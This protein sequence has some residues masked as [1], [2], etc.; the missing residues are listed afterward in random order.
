MPKNVQ[1]RTN[2]S[3]YLLVQNLTNI[4]A[5]ITS[6]EP[7]DYLIGSAFHDFELTIPVIGEL[8]SSLTG[9]EDYGQVYF[10]GPTQMV[11][12]CPRESMHA[13]A[14]CCVHL[15]QT[16]ETVVHA[17]VSEHS[18]CTGDNTQRQ[19]LKDLFYEFQGIFSRDSY[20]CGITDIYTA[21][22]PTDPNAPAT[23]IHQ[24]K[25]LLAAFESIQGILDS[26]LEKKIIQECN[27]TYNSPLWPVL[28]PSGKW[29]LTIDYRQLNKQVPLS[30]WPMILLD[31]ELAVT[32]GKYF[33]TVDGCW[34]MKVD[35]VDQHKLAFSF[36][37]RQFT[38]N[39]CPFGYSN[40]GHRG[41]KATYNTLQQVVYWPFMARDI[42]KYVKGCLVCCQFQPS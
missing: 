25:I 39:R 29:H 18:W 14:I 28:K 7:L 11:S 16:N 32:N 3:A 36:G 17:I 31:Q 15:S 19:E 20:S 5:Q 2:R 30:R 38:W 6:H 4:T 13:N 21:H 12:I 1:A 35:P 10:T 23:F 40:P 24:Y 27:S 26:L 8:P 33:S 9:A 41:S 37:N 42:T 22:I 34:T